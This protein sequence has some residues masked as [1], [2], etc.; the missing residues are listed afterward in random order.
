[1]GGRVRLCPTLASVPVENFQ[2]E[3]QALSLPFSLSQFYFCN[4][5][6]VSP[7]QTA[8]KLMVN[9]VLIIDHEEVISHILGIITCRAG[10]PTNFLE[11]FN[12][13]Y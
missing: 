5:T 10:P 11:Q 9:L 13:N 4:S 8:K 2:N 6:A 1:M 12:R 7:S 3:R